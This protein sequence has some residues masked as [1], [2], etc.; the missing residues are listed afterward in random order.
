MSFDRSVRNGARSL[1]GVLAASVLAL[2]A[3]AC[4]NSSSGPQ[5]GQASASVQDNPQTTTPDRRTSGLHALAAT[6]GSGGFSGTLTGNAK[7]QIQTSSGTWIDLG[8]LS[9]ADVHLQDASGETVVSQSTTVQAGTYVA[10]RLVLTNVHAHLN[11]GG[12][13][14]G[15]TLSSNADLTVGGSDDQVTITKQVNVQVNGSAATRVVFDLNTEQWFDSSNMQSGVVA[16][17]RVQSAVEAATR[18]AISAS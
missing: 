10:V 11:A 4:S 18:T 13:V 15:S 1:A 7:V 16:D 9:Q 5:M 2:G 8:S 17:S 12:T 14:G 6:S 3:T